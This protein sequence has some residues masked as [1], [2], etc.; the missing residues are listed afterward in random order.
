MLFPQAPLSS[1]PFSSTYRSPQCPPLLPSPLS[2]PLRGSPLYPLCPPLLSLSSSPAVGGLAVFPS[3]VFG[4]SVDFQVLIC[5]FVAY[6]GSAFRSCFS[7]ASSLF[8]GFRADF[9]YGSSRFLTAL[10]LLCFNPSSLL[11]GYHCLFGL[12]HTW[13]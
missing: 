6:R 12:Y 13:L 7:L 4:V 9:A 3:K 1:A 11:C 2:G 8:S 5:W 10:F